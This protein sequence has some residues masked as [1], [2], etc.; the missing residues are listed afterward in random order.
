M[1]YVEKFFVELS[2]GSERGRILGNENKVYLERLLWFGLR[3]RFWG[4]WLEGYFI[5]GEC[6]V[7]RE[8]M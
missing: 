5:F 3:G 2:K 7:D 8:D 1:I 6:L 4:S